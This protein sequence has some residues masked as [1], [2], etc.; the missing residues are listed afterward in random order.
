MAKRRMPQAVEWLLREGGDD[1]PVP[2]S[3]RMSFEDEHWTASIERIDIGESL[4]VFLTK[5]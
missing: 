5:A 3:S 4:R 1:Q 2:A